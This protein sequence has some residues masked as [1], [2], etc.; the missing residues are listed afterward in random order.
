MENFNY[1]FLAT[2]MQEFW[3]RWHISLSSWCRDYIFHPILALS[4]NRWLAL[5]AAMLV[6]AL[7]HEISWRYIAWGCFHAALILL[8]V[9]S[10]K[11]FPFMHA[12]F[13]QNTFGR[14]TGRLLVFHCFAFSCLFLMADNAKEL[15]NMLYQL[16]GH[17]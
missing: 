11:K 9:Y 8:V 15:Q 10:R 16:L 14:W 6:L 13:K 12:W 17:V 1:P 5:V 7:W 4:R 2:D 3:T